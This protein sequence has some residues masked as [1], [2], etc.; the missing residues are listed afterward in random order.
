MKKLKYF[1]VPLCL[2]I[3]LL[4]TASVSYAQ[5]PITQQLVGNPPQVVIAGSSAMFVLSHLAA[6]TADPVTGAPAL[7]GSHSWS[8]KTSGHNFAFGVD[9]RVTA[10]ESGNI[11][12]VWNTYT[13]PA[14][15]TNVCVYFS[16]DSVIG[17]RLFYAA[18]NCSGVACYSTIDITHGG[19]ANP[20]GTAGDNA[21]PYFHDTDVLPQEVALLVQ[22]SVITSAATDIRP[23]DAQFAEYRAIHGFGYPNG[24]SIQSLFSNGVANVEPFFLQGPDPLS[25][26]PVRSSEVIRVGAEPLMHFVN[27]TSTANPGDFGN[28]CANGCNTLSH[29]LGV[30]YA[31]APGGLIGLTSDVVGSSATGQ[32]LKITQ[33]EPTSGTYNTFEWQIPEASGSGGSQETPLQPPTPT[34]CGLPQNSV[35]FPAFINCGNPA[36]RKD[37]ITGAVRGRAIGTG[38]MVNVVKN[39]GN[40]NAIGYAF[41]AFSNFNAVTT[42]RYMTV[43]GIDPLGLSLYNGQFPQCTGRIDAPPLVCPHIPFT[44]VASGNYRNW[45]VL[46]VAVLDAATNAN[47]NANMH[48]FIL[49]AQDQGDPTVGTLDDFLP[50]QSCSTFVAGPPVQCTAAKADL[51]VFRSHYALP[52]FAGPTLPNVSTNPINAN[53]GVG[54]AG[55]SGGTMH[56]AIFYV[57]NDA[58]FFL[59][60]GSTAELVSYLQ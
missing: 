38:E 41:W 1:A 40:P 43:D 16:V 51:S 21:D 13:P 60:S 19:T 46:S 28:L 31:G 9:P 12:I 50:V 26:A 22:G 2:A 49:S 44:G 4:C 47:A 56:G 30:L 59:D 10:T 42:T 53:P 45:N 39:A 37:P 17:D 18:G 48:A 6:G 35:V 58:N 7:C 23:E 29:T 24:S 3:A 52:T 8:S 20:I 54:P 55:E 14:N 33:R 25:S 15:P 27:T 34:T 5:F 36:Y 32:P 57:V 11:W